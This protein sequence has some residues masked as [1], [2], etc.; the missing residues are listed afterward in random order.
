MQIVETS[1]T[2]AYRKE[3]ATYNTV[4][5]PLPSH[6]SPRH[7]PYLL[8]IRTHGLHVGHYPPQPVS[9]LGPAPTLSPFF[10]LAQA[11]FEP[12]LV[13]Y[14]YLNILNPS[15]SS[16]LPAY[17]WNRQNVLKRWHIKFRRWRITQKKAYNKDIYVWN[18]TT[19]DTIQLMWQRTVLG[20][21]RCWA[22]E[23]GWCL[24]CCAHSHKNSSQMMGSSFVSA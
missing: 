9:L 4:V 11:I 22:Q 2:E 24:P 23:R 12:N 15:H 6:G 7:A 19:R 8:H 17:R 10:S 13:L 5:W 18:V 20:V 16:Y 14:K 1:S 3:T 21:R